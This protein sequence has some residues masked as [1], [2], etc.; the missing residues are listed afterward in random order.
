M[1]RRA[2]YKSGGLPWLLIA[3][4]LLLVLVFFYWPTMQALYWAKEKA[5]VRMTRPTGHGLLADGQGHGLG[6]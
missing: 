1:E 4:Q 6:T 5:S 2:Y 3:P